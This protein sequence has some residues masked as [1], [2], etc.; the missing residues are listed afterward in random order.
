MLV[1]LSLLLAAAPAQAMSVKEYFD[2][3]AAARIKHK[4]SPV[5]LSYL[6]GAL[7]SLRSAN[8]LADRNGRARL[9]CDPAESPPQMDNVQAMLRQD[10]A[11]MRRASSL[12]EFDAA[13]RSMELAQLLLMS[14]QKHYPCEAASVPPPAADQ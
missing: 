11:E 13:I 14:L 9:Y 8:A 2:L 3:E 10:A 4:R 5:L 7:E 1:T 6:S 12:Q